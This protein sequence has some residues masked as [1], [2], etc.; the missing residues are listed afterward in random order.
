[1]NMGMNMNQITPAN[2][3][4]MNTKGKDDQM[5]N[6]GMDQNQS[7]NQ[8]QNQNQNQ[9]MNMNMNN[10]SNNP[11]SAYDLVDFNSLDLSSLNMD[12]L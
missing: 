1:M 10:D 6:I 5:Q 4:S 11:K 12:F 8:N 7:Q 9:S 3:L 2:I